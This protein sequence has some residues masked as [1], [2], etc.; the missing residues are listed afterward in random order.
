M[1]PY[2]C[3]HCSEKLV[4]SQICEGGEKKLIPTKRVVRTRLAATHEFLGDSKTR[5][6]K[7]YA[8]SE[9]ELTTVRPHEN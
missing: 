4:C 2:L 9:T 1:N 5:I 7:I 8:I 3:E 6:I